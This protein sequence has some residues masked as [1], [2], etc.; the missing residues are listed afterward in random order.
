MINKLMYIAA[1]I[2]AWG[3]YWIGHFISK[4]PQHKLTYVLN[5]YNSAMQASLFFSDWGN[6]KVWLDADE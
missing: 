4:L 2:P 6:I 5:I 3:F 1:F